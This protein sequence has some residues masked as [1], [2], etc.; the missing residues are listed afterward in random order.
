MKKKVTLIVTCVA[1][2]AA[3][4]VGGTLAFFTDNDK[5]ENVVT[6]GNVSI[7]LT[8]PNYSKDPKYDEASAGITGAMPGDLITKD[9]TVKND[10]SNPAWIRVKVEVKWSES[11]NPVPN[12]EDLFELNTD[13]VDGKD[14]Y[15]YY[16][17]KLESGGE[18]SILFQGDNDNKN[19]IKIPE[20][21]T[22]DTIKNTGSLQI[23]VTAEAL[24]SEN[25]DIPANG[26]IED[27][28]TNV[29]VEP[30]A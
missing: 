13:W 15:Y 19:Q 17:K 16:T 3:I 18:T 23:N 25:N 11:Q 7:S 5:V 14:G 12:Q 1:L 28:W 4:V 20:D 6:F 26:S 30:A 27:V 8:E 9:P 21:W 10:G 22:Q 29:T 2:V 24:Q